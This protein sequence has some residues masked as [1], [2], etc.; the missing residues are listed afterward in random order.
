MLKIKGSAA[1]NPAGSNA[2]EFISVYVNKFSEDSAKK[3]YE[4]FNRAVD[5]GQ[6]VVPIIIDSYG[7]S[8]DAGM[9]MYDV[10]T[11]ADVSVATVAVGKAMSCGSFLLSCGDEGMRFASPNSRIMVH[12]ISAGSWGKESDLEVNLKEIKRLK[13]L[14]FETMSVNCGHGKNYFAELLSQNSDK[15]MYFSPKEALKH[16]IINEIR[17]PQVQKSV[18]FELV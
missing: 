13:K 12:N 3:F 10:I 7:G 4:D 1:D 14:F 11:S 2:G 15:D 6:A 9:F 8:V 18:Y 16:G 17:L 5:T